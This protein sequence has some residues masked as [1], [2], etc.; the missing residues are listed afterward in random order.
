MAVGSAAV[1]AFM[2]LPLLFSDNRTYVIDLAIN[3]AA[4]LLDKS[5][6]H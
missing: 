1:L 6:P 5:I 3:L 2:L 4:E